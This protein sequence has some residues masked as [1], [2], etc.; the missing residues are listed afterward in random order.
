MEDPR[1]DVL[2]ASNEANRLGEIQAAIS[3]LVGPT[4]IVAV[5]DEDCGGIVAYVLEP[6]ANELVAAL[7]TM[8]VIS[9]AVASLESRA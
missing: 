8:E 7:N 3:A 5:V 6:F 1:Y 9:E 4:P 2:D